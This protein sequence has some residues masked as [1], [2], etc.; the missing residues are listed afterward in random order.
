MS[1]PPSIPEGSGE[2]APRIIGRYA[3]HDEIAAGGMA[4]VHLGR[5]LGP[6]GFSRTVAIKR[7]HPQF[8]KD[9]EFVAMFLDEARLAARIRHP[10]V[11]P[12]L[13]VVALDHELF[14]VMEYV[15]GESLSRLVRA[16][17]KVEAAIPLNLV[18]TIM[19]GVLHGL[20]AA[21]EAKTEQGEPLSIVHRDVS[22]Q[23][24]LVG[25]DG[26]PRVLDFGVA[27]AAI[28]AQTTRQGQ[29]KGKVA[30]MAPEQLRAEAVDR[31]CDV[32]AAA[33]VLW[34]AVTRKRMFQADSEAAVLAMVLFQ[35]PISP[36]TV[37]PDLDENLER[38]IMRG[39]ERD[40]NA[41]YATAR[42]M[43]LELETCLPV[44]SASSIGAWVER[45]A[46]DALSQRARRMSDIESQ[47][48]SP[49]LVSVGPSPASPGPS[50]DAGSPAA[51][52]PATGAASSEGP[53]M[54]DLPT[55]IAPSSLRA[56]GEA[57]T[58]VSAA[59]AGEEVTGQASIVSAI[60]ELPPSFDGGA[61][62]RRRVIAAA[63]GVAALGLIGFLALRTSDP[64]APG[65][66]ADAPSG[67]RAEPSPPPVV[68]ATASPAPTASGTATS[69]ASAAPSASATPRRPTAPSPPA[70]PAAPARAAAPP[71]RPAANCT[72][73]YTIDGAGFRHMKPECL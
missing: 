41:R 66:N 73:P 31:R 36:R 4:T 25:V 20:H 72:P 45:L 8:A 68:A 57:R 40:P 27:K 22:P 3:L 44:A 30:Y 10:N 67:A 23:N 5:L 11:V 64:P 19:A 53:A 42:E 32:F 47:T 29:V 52:G 48:S 7:L 18:T 43:A 37:V 55:T 56:T 71:A 1:T 61:R 63:A 14:L 16:S 69:A 49:M 2:G 51:V 17:R 38:I 59:S 46:H 34:E 50:A 54:E 12:T 62:T 24:V 58:K 33:A 26:V 15:Q 39:L 65:G 21:H 35:P 6:V 13:D 9:P 28:R 70:Q 60:N